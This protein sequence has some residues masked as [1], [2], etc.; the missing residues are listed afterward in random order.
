MTFGKITDITDISVEAF[1]EEIDDGIES[2]SLG[3]DGDLILKG[4]V[5]EEGAEGL[6]RLFFEGVF[7]RGYIS[8]ETV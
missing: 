6:I 2:L 7:S 5:V 1:S 8:F 3:G 4:E